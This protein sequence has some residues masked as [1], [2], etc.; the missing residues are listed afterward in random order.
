MASKYAEVYGQWQ[1]D[2]EVFWGNAAKEIDWIKPPTKVFDKDAGVYGRWF[3]D[4]TCNTC[5]N[6]IDRHVKN[7]RADQTALI[8]DSPVTD[9]KRKYTYACLLYT[10]R[11]V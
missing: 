8:Y 10:S 4:A 2:P 3:P 5:Y 11:C 6:A 1:K 9:S 7:G